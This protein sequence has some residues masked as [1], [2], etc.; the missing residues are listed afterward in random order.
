MCFRKIGF[1]GVNW[2]HAAQERN[3]TERSVCKAEVLLTGRATVY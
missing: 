2:I 1:E 3:G